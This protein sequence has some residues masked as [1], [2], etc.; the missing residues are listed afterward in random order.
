MYLEPCFHLG[1]KT[2]DRQTFNPDRGLPSLLAHLQEPPH[3][4]AGCG[5]AVSNPAGSWGNGYCRLL[6]VLVLV[7]VLACRPKIIYIL[8]IT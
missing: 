8:A 6:L 7:L 3:D 2:G 1:M 5:R 4:T